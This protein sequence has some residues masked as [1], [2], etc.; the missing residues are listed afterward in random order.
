MAGQQQLIYREFLVDAS[1]R[2][3][4][5]A[6]IGVITAIAARLLTTGSSFGFSLWYHPASSHEIS[7][8]SLDWVMYLGGALLLGSLVVSVILHFLPGGKVTGPPDTLHSLADPDQNVTLK[9]GF[10]S[11]LIAGVSTAS[12][13]SV[14]LYGPLIHF[15]GLVAELM[16]RWF[17]TMHIFM[18]NTRWL[19]RC[20]RDIRRVSDSHWRGTVRD[21]VCHA[22]N[23][24]PG[25]FAACCGKFHRMGRCA[26]YG[27]D[28]RLSVRTQQFSTRSQQLNHSCNHGP[29][30]RYGRDWFY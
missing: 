18:A 9:T 24:P 5:S 29:S 13:S 12:G 21:R 30:V 11:T 22:Q 10:T 15:G 3:L 28:A 4:A 26:R 1:I 27:F 2:I 19:R 25:F 20:L 14:G 23:E 7:M 8:P 16:R 17:G 6:A